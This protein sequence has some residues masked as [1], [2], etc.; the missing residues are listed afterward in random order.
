VDVCPANI[1]HCAQLLRKIL[2]LIYTQKNQAVSRPSKNQ[3]VRLTCQFL[4]ANIPTVTRLPAVLD[5]I[6]KNIFLL[7]S[8]F[9]TGTHPL[10]SRCE[11]KWLLCSFAFKF[12]LYKPRTPSLIIYFFYTVFF[13]QTPSWKPMRTQMI[14]MLFLHS[15]S[16]VQVT[17]LNK[18]AILSC[19]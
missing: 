3:T 14:V 15:T 12:S 13:W 11:L 9:L 19:G 4:D 6:I 8:I 10:G 1:I 2:L 16:C 18:C 17:F 5:S 7:Y